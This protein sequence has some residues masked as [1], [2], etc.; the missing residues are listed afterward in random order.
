MHAR[1]RLLLPPLLMV[2]RV[3]RLLLLLLLLGLKV[4]AVAAAVSA[5]ELVTAGVQLHLLTDM[6]LL[7]VGRGG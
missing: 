5:A 2:Q 4:R 7:L 3:R 6:L 1:C